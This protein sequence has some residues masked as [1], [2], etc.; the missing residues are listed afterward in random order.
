MCSTTLVSYLVTLWF[1][2]YAA[3]NWRVCFDFLLDS[4]NSLEKVIADG[5]TFGKL[6]FLAHCNGTKVEVLRGNQC[7]ID[8]FRQYVVKCATSQYNYMV[9]FFDRAH[10]MQV[11]AFNL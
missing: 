6:A 1:L 9:S 4:R 3:G 8:E 2:H 11:C 10:F 5:L 7:T